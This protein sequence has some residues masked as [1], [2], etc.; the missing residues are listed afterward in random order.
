MHHKQRQKPFFAAF[1][2]GLPPFFIRP[3]RFASKARKLSQSSNS[4]Q[5]RRTALTGVHGSESV[6]T[7]TAFLR[8]NSAKSELSPF[9]FDSKTTPGESIKQMCLSS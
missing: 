9:F 5:R 2:S 7:L 4:E 6:S 1:K 3:E 8:A